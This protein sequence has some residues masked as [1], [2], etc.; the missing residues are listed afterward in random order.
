M[1]KPGAYRGLST[2][3]NAVEHEY[4][5]RISSGQVLD[6]LK[7]RDDYTTHRPIRTNYPTQKVWVGGINQLHQGDLIDLSTI[8]KK[9]NK[10]TFLLAIIDCF[11]REAFVEPM[12]DK[13][14]NSVLKALE[15]VYK[16]P[17]YPIS[18][19]SDFGKEFSNRKVQNFFAKNEIKFMT[20]YG[21]TKCAFIERFIETF[22][23]M[24]WRYMTDKA[25]YKYVDALQD[26][27]SSY[28][29]TYHRSIG[30]APSQ[31][32][33]Q[34]AKSVFN[35][36]YGDPGASHLKPA[37]KRG[38]KN[39][40]FKVGDHVRIAVKKGPFEKGYSQTYS[41]EIYKVSERL[42]NMVPVQYRLESTTRKSKVNFTSKK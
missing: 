17:D 14:A 6:F 27:V 21:N 5:G 37:N 16:G 32:S 31:V 38:K 28:N 8:S 24:L 1:K 23:H 29:K 34:N 42:K 18:F 19:M 22:K 7:T 15:K 25:T 10:V 30:M 39:Y 26:L 9:N 35:H 36:M 41:S 40:K 4:K 20:P 33:E 2:F 11:S 13:S 12:L 3:A